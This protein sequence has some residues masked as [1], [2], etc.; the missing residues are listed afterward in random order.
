MVL[1]L[2]TLIA[3]INP[4]LI[5]LSLVYVQTLFSYLGYCVRV[6]AEAENLVSVSVKLMLHVII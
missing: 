5:G 3:G 4:T 2:A 6:G 1:I